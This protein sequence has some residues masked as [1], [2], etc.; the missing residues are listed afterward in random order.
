MT[1]R[2]ASL[3]PATGQAKIAEN[4]QRVGP[5]R[6][7]RPVAARSPVPARRTGFLRLGGTSAAPWSV[8]GSA[9]RSDATTVP[10]SAPGGRFDGPDSIGLGV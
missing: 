8:T 4:D 6:R 3:R 2:P 7:P 1:T 5:R 10:A 9:S